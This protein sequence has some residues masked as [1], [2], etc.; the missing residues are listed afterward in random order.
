M[1]YQI[2]RQERATWKVLGRQEASNQNT[3]FATFDEIAKALQPG[4]EVT[5]TDT[6]KAAELRRDYRPTQAEIEERAEQRFRRHVAG[7]EEMATARLVKFSAG[8][9]GIVEK[10][11]SDPMHEFEWADSAF[12]AAGRLYV[13][14][15]ARVVFD[16]H[17]V[18][19]TLRETLAK[20]LARVEEEVHRGAKYPLRSTGSRDLAAAL[21]L[22]AW[23]DMAEYLRSLVKYELGE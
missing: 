12:E 13:A 23:A 7:A 3:A 14:R 20:L 15:W 1:R 21:K 2:L 6:V 17:R 4:E 9:C 11:D 16:E 10:P 18:S 22:A 8:L 5:L 19:L